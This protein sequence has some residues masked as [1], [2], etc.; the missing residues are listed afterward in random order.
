V[1]AAFPSAWLIIAS[2]LRFHQ[3]A[4][5]D[6][7][8]TVESVGVANLRTGRIEARSGLSAAGP[9]AIRVAGKLPIVLQTPVI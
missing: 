5:G 8:R 9:V 4:E 7:D 1:R 6:R 2:R 3:G